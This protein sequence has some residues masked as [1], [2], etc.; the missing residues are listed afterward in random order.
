MSS[1]TA[2]TSTTST[3]S[4]LLLNSAATSINGGSSNSF[5]PPSSSQINSSFTATSTTANINKLNNQNVYD[6][7]TPSI[8]ASPM[9]ISSDRLIRRSSST[10]AIPNTPAVPNTPAI[11]NTPT[12]GYLYQA[13]PFPIDDTMI[14]SSNNAIN[15]LSNRQMVEPT[16]NNGTELSDNNNDNNT[17]NGGIGINASSNK[18]INE[19]SGGDFDDIFGDEDSSQSKKPK[20]D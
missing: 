3:T 4:P 19:Q 20:I 9:P 12:N 17:V 16:R 6:S 5:K 8:S 18:Q 2:A 14:N 15:M 13:S 1:S 7:G 10:L 11:P